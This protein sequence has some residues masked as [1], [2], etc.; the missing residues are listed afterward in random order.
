LGYL[1][2]PNLPRTAFEDASAHKDTNI[3]FERDTRKFKDCFNMVPKRGRERIEALQ[4][5]M[6]LFLTEC[7]RAI[8]NRTG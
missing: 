2:L 8:K 4:I 5:A 1:R 3:L 7:T 6:A